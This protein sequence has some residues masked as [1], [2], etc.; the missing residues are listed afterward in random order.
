M[1][2]EY[3]DKTG[4]PVSFD[5]FVEHISEEQINQL[6]TEELERARTL[7][8]QMINFKKTLIGYQDNTINNATRDLGREPIRVNGQITDP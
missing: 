1:A 6:T 3:K 2:L 8:T 5:K 4:A 7:L